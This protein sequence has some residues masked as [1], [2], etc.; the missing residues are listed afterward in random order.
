VLTDEVKI[1]LNMLGA[2]IL[3]GVGEEVDRADIVAVDQSGPQQGVVPAPQVV[4]E[5][6][7]PPLRCGHSAVLCLS[8][9]T[10]DDVVA[11]KHRIAQSGPASVGT[12]YPVSVNVDDEVRRRV[13]AKKQ[14][15]V[16]GSLDVVE[17]A[18]HDREMGLMGVVHVEAYLLDRVDVKPVEGKVL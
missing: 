17:D 14:T 18:L 4:V 12:T 5:A 6:R 15:M 3:D 11:Q 9:Q 10:G 8:A 1:N 2:L 7:T 16:E 13:T